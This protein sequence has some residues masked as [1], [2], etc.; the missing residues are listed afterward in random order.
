MLLQRRFIMERRWHG[1]W[2][3]GGS[4]CGIWCES[5]AGFSTYGETAGNVINVYDTGYK[6]TNVSSPSIVVSN[7]SAIMLGLPSM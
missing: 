2:M 5:L 6:F 1:C 7:T 3:V 4:L